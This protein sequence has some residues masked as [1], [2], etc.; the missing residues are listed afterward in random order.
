MFRGFQ[1]NAV[2][3]LFP[4][5]IYPAWVSDIKKSGHVHLLIEGLDEIIIN[6]PLRAGETVDDYAMRLVGESPPIH[7]SQRWV[8]VEIVHRDDGD[9]VTAWVL[10]EE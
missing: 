3:G 7:G 4:A 6:A 1:Q 8:T 9:T 5:G 10:T 2:R